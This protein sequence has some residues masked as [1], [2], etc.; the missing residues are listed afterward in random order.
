MVVDFAELFQHDV[1]LGPKVCI[2]RTFRDAGVAG[3]IVDGH[4]FVVIFGKQPKGGF[5]N[6]G[7]GLLGLQLSLCGTFFSV[8][9]NAFLLLLKHAG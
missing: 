9:H 1:V 6:L 3:D 2:E 4:I 5:E 8:F 7:A